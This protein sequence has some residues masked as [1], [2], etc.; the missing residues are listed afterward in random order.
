M[1]RRS[2]KCDE[3]L[4]TITGNRGDMAIIE[5][6]L[7]PQHSDAPARSIDRPDGPLSAGRATPPPSELESDPPRHPAPA[8]SELEP[9]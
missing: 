5:P 7:I 3:P 6:F 1:R 4:P 9:I 2:R 8:G